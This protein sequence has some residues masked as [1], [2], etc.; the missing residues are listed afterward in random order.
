MKQQKEQ[1]P[2]SSV[3]CGVGHRKHGMN[4]F[5]LIKLFHTNSEVIL[6]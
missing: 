4:E 2:L 1:S 6:K 3:T 5:F